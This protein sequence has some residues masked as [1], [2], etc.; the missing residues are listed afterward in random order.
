MAAVLDR[1]VEIRKRPF[2][3]T[4]DDKVIDMNLLGSMFTPTFR[5]PVASALLP[6]FHRQDSLEDWRSL[7]PAG[8]FR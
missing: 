3:K 6:T 8:L 2:D 7:R 5:H 1:A 4:I